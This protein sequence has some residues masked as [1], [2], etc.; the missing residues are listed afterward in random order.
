MSHKVFESG[1]L[2]EN[3]ILRSFLIVVLILALLVLSACLRIVPVSRAEPAPTD[4]TVGQDVPPHWVASAVSL[5]AGQKLLL[6]DKYSLFFSNIPEMPTEPGILL[7]VNN[8]LSSSGLV[9]VLFSHL[10]LLIDWTQD[11]PQNIPATAGFA[12]E[13]H[14][15]RELEVYALKS[16][17]GVSRAPDGTKLFLEDAAPV[18]PGE[19]EPLYYG[20]AVGN[21]TVC[22]WFLSEEKPPVH[23]GRVAPGSRIIVSET[24]GPRGWITGIYDLKFIDAATGVQIGKENLAEGESVGI[25]SFIAPAECD[26]GSFLD[27]YSGYCLLPPAGNDRLHMRGL[28]V[29][30]SYE[31][32][33]GGEA[34]SKSFTVSYNVRE[35][36]SAGFTLAAGE[37]D[38]CSDPKAPGYVPDV[39]LNDRMRNGF[40]PANP[41]KQGLNGG[42]YGID[43]TVALQLTGPVALAVQGATHSDSRGNPE[44]VDMYNQILT[45]WLDGRVR[46]IQIKDPN[47]E[48]YYMDTV[49][50]RPPGYGKVI[51]V[52]PETGRHDHLLRFTLP[53]NGY[54]P[55][56]FYLLPLKEK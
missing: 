24:V 55:V 10:N 54:G 35:G 27:E 2:K 51:G 16:A 19:S 14:T 6:D 29:A 45:F 11:H 28:F 20:S 18:R 7:D 34:V 44:F 42:N 49:A 41:G 47:Y 21:Y 39:F 36:Q 30:G 15:A 38:Q 22:Q 32:N 9:R 50:M 13:N 43:Y 31:D 33:P 1:I 40:D 52:F 23:L 25:K 46:T 3:K 5:S 8:V 37:N 56:R 53:P 17:I 48:R 26:P 12:V 4:F